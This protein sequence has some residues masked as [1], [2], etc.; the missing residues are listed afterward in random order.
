[1]SAISTPTSVG[2]DSVRT[3]SNAFSAINSEDFVAMML[4][5]LSNQDPLQPND[6]QQLLDQISSI[7]SIESD[8]SLLES[9][10]GMVDS[11]EFASASNL[12]GTLVSGLTEQGSRTSDVVLSVS[13]TTDGPVLNLFNG[14]RVPF[15]KVD[16]VV[17][18]LDL[19]N[20]DGSN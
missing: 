1:M 15:D 4:S 8:Q 2:T 5:E 10:N 12:I 7:R 16:E 14:T 19:S 9:L 18:P 3:P 13:R 6:T 11:N 20:S 17:A